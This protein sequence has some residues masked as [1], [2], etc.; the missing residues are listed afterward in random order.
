MY[1]YTYVCIYRYI[2]H[3][4]KTVLYVSILYIEHSVVVIL[5]KNKNNTQYH[6]VI[7]NWHHRNRKYYRRQ[8]AK[9]E[10]NA[11]NI[12]P[13]IHSSIFIFNTSRKYFFFILFLLFFI[14]SIY[15]GRK[16]YVVSMNINIF[17][18]IWKIPYNLLTV[19]N[20][21][22]YFFLYSYIQFDTL[23]IF[24]IFVYLFLQKNYITTY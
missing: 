18:N 3:F 21:H 6:Q 13:S 10:K 15:V 19:K 1:L 20:I 17:F 5:Y 7:F 12:H 9:S 22:S 8:L 2:Y 24:I 16:H 11:S 4:I 14:F 23:Y